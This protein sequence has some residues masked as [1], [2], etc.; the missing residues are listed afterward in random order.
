LNPHLGWRRSLGA[1]DGAGEETEHKN[2]D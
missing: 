2:K 1:Q